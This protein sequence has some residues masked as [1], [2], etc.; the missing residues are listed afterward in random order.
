[1]PPYF[2][3]GVFY[4]VVRSWARCFC[5]HLW[6]RNPGDLKVLGR[7]SGVGW[8]TSGA[9]WSCVST[10]WASSTVGWLGGLVVGAGLCGSVRLTVPLCWH[11]SAHADICADTFRCRHVPTCVEMCRHL[12][13]CL[14]NQSFRLI[15]VPTSGIRWYMS[16][17]GNMPTCGDMCW[18]VPTCANMWHLSRHLW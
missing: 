17:P 7:F 13:E 3:L 18:H 1:M 8:A 5:P 12:S 10:V 2:E 9:L 11:V 4:A 6:C 16:T 15:Q 14:W